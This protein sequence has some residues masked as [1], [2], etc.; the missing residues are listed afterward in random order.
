MGEARRTEIMET[1]RTSDGTGWL[2][3]S[4]AI[5]YVYRGGA[6]SLVDVVQIAGSTTAY[7][8]FDTAASGYLS[9][10]PPEF[11]TTGGP[12]LIKIYAGTDYT[13]S[14]EMNVRNRNVHSSQVNLASLYSGATGSSKGTEIVE[15]AIPSGHK[16]SGSMSSSLPY[17]LDGVNY[18]IEVQ[19]LD[20]NAIYFG[21]NFTWFED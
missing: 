7:F 16:S 9:V 3:S 5:D 17:V 8:L 19:N 2:S 6:F 4:Y 20:S 11:S 12:V 14:T 10:H 1:T 21:I 18:L 13:A 15:Y